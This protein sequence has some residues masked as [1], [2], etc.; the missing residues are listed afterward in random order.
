MFSSVFTCDYKPLF[1]FESAFELMYGDSECR[2]D[3]WDSDNYEEAYPSVAVSYGLPYV[4]PIMRRKL[5][6]GVRA[7]QRA[8]WILEDAGILEDESEE[9]YYLYM[10][11]R[12]LE[13]REEME[14]RLR[15]LS[16]YGR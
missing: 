14:M 2:D 6:F 10:Y 15:M 1:D 13:E 4:P 11:E 3:Y 7:V 9:E 8:E 16:L 5:P 12:E